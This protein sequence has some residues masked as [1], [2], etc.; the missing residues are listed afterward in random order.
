VLKRLNSIEQ[1]WDGAAAV[2]GDDLDLGEAFLGAGGDHVGDHASRIKHEFDYGGVQSIERDFP[3]LCDR[4][5]DEKR[6]HDSDFK[7][8]YAAAAKSCA[9]VRRAEKGSAMCPSGNRRLD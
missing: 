4:R 5:V 8:R 6:R 3:W 7:A 1:E 2:G 9:W